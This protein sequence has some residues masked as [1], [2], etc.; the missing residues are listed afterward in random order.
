MGSGF[1]VVWIVLAVVL[2]GVGGAVLAPLARSLPDRGLSLGVPA[3]LVVLWLGARSIGTRSITLGLLAGLTLVFA[4]GAL[5]RRSTSMGRSPAALV[6]LAIALGVATATQSLTGLDPT[7]T[8]A[9]AEYGTLRTLLRGGP[10]PPEA[11]WVAGE[12]VSAPGTVVASLLARIALTPAHYAAPLWTATS[13]A[14]IVTAAFGIGAA[15]ARTDELRLPSAVAAAAIVGLASPVPLDRALDWVGRPVPAG[16]ATPAAWLTAPF[17][18]GTLALL[19]VV[20][21]AGL[22]AAVY[23]WPAVD[24]RERWLAVLAVGVVAGVGA[25][26]DPWVGPT[27]VVLAGLTVACAPAP[28]IEIGDRPLVQTEPTRWAVATIATLAVG[29]VALAI[30]WPETPH[31]TLAAATVGPPGPSI[32]ATLIAIAVLGAVPTLGLWAALRARWDRP[33]AIVITASALVVLVVA[34]DRPIAAL[35]GALAVLAV[36]LARTDGLDDRPSPGFAAVL[37]AVSALAVAARVLIADPVASASLTVQAWTLIAIAT[38]P[39]VVRLGSHRLPSPAGRS[40]PTA[41][42]ALNSVAVAVVLVGVLATPIVIA[43]DHADSERDLAATATLDLTE[44]ERQ[45]TA[46]L[47]ER[48][49]S[50]TIVT[51]P[52]TDRAALP[53]V[54]SGL[55]TVAGPP[56]PPGWPARTDERV[57]AVETI[58]TGDPAAQRHQLEAFDVRYV[59]VGPAERARYDLALDGRDALDPVA[60]SEDW[61]TVTIYRVETG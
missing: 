54:I 34:H 43:H 27:I 51:A 59:Y 20:L 9:L 1:A 53:S 16:P 21:A 55:P 3:A 22:L 56:T 31:R 44:S 2:A 52:D 15:L 35:A 6:V 10:L 60:E 32:D 23:R 30:A 37:I 45:A 49:G 33:N 25:T 12:S 41:R 8:T 42:R 39:A 11:I 38:G 58:Y 13:Y 61:P 28:P 57:T 14:A 5:A 26:V 29:A 47:N 24:R 46:W 40:W 36:G 48:P 17:E 18:G 7:Q 4:L 50:P 19:T